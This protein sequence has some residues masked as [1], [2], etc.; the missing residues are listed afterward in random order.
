[1][2]RSDHENFNSETTGL[3]VPLPKGKM[4]LYRR[5]AKDGRPEFT[6]ESSIDHTAKDEAVRLDNGY[7]FDLTAERTQTDFEMRAGAGQ[8]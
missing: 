1:M 8:A 3:E 6:G 2:K 4:R 5:D 7:A